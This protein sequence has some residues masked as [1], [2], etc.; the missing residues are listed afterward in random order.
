MV[1]GYRS[2]VE[3]RSNTMSRARTEALGNA[4]QECRGVVVRGGGTSIR[5]S[6]PLSLSFSLP[7]SLSSS[8]RVIA[9]SWRAVHSRF[10]PRRQGL[11]ISWPDRCGSGFDPTAFIFPRTD[12]GSFATSSCG[13]SGGK[14]I[15]VSKNRRNVRTNAKRNEWCSNGDE[16][17]YVQELLV[18]FSSIVNQT[19]WT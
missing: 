9:S 2:R 16:F 8:F 18:F 10:R 12:D 19:C 14:W 17:E 13:T 11:S 7:L 3:E 6:L 1:T 5:V 4:I 15:F